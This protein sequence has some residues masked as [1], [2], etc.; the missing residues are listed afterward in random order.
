MLRRRLARALFGLLCLAPMLAHALAVVSHSP[1]RNAL[2]QSRSPTIAVQFDRPV[3]TTSVTPATFRVFGRSGGPLPGDIT[4]SNGNQTLNFTPTR[5]LFPGEQVSVNLANSITAADATTLR[6]GGYAFQFT[7]V[8]GAASM[9]MNIIDTVS[10]RTSAATT[11]L[12]GGNFV[13]FNRDGW[14]D[15]IAV[16]EVSAD[17]R[18]LLNRADGSGKLGP[19]L[20]P[21]RQIGVEASPN[22]SA[23]FDND[24]LMDFATGNGTSNSVSI[25]LGNGDGTFDPQQELAV[26]TRPHGIAVLD[27]DGDGDLDVVAASELGTHPNGNTL[28]VLRNNGAGV[29]T[30]V[31]RID[32]G[33]NGEYPL[34][35]GD[36]DND[37]ILDLVVG[38][39]TD[40][41]VHVMH[42]NGDGTFT[43]V[44]NRAAGG[45]T[46]MFALGDV[47]GDGNLDLASV[48]G[49]NNNGAILLGNG[50]GTLDAPTIHP[51]GGGMVATDL[52]DLDGDGDLDWVTSSFGAG[53]WY[54]MRNN[55][56]G[57][58]QQVD[59]VDAP[60][61]ASCA[62]LYDF[63]NDDDLD[64]ALAD[65]IADVIVLVQNG[66]SVLFRD[67]FENP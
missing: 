42:G 2:N 52:G 28:N 38:T 8:A 34:V 62:S 5:R 51:F 53:L 41:Q 61:N 24:G 23:D 29:F 65:E 16:N 20:M 36:M 55:G 57:N 47:D 9:T 43:R 31:L 27:A 7:T 12:Y 14:I 35:S 66:G 58:F 21:P 49:F 48:N 32:T 17:L 1:T 50:D 25:V 44:H 26:G 22:E 15:Y 4:Y 63:D 59:T 37:G 64:L 46:W 33:G 19:V 3:L 40:N 6:Q 30:N 13:D 10:V 67:S 54:I 18:V 11:R 45:Y 39:A 56:G 60:N